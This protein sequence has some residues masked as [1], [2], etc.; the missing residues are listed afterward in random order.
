M[1]VIGIGCPIGVSFVLQG[2][3]NIS[4]VHAFAAGAA[5]CS[6]SLGTTF[7][8]LSTTGLTESRLGVVLS[9]AAMMD[10]VFGLMMVQVISNLGQASSFDPVTVVRPVMVSIGFAVLLPVLCR[11]VVKPLTLKV[12]LS[13]PEDETSWLQRLVYSKGSVLSLHTTVIIAMV[14]GASYAGTSNLFA[15]YLAGAAISWWSELASTSMLVGTTSCNQQQGL[16]NKNESNQGHK[17]RTVS[18]DGSSAPQ[19][20]IPTDQEKA[21]NEV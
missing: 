21:E 20:L 5:L 15:A 2:L 3:R 4:P 8:V 18:K 11:W 16:G 19:A 17:E 6:T 14:T 1:A 10:D 13:R 7:T 9:S 12:D